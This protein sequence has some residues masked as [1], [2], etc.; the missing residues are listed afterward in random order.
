MFDKCVLCPRYCKVNRDKGEFGYC[1]CGNKMIIARYSLHKWEEPCL[2]GDIGSGTIFFSGCN[3]KC[4]Y[5]QNYEISVLRYGRSVSV[6]EFCYMCLDLQN[7]GAKNINLVTGVMYIPLIVQGIKLAREKGL[8]IPIVYNS[9]GY[10][11][12]EGLKLLE[13]IVDI[14]LPDFKYFDD[15]LGLKYS[16]VRDYNKYAIMAIKEMYRQVGRNK[17][18]KDGI[19]IRGVIVRHLILPGCGDD[20]KKVIKYLYNNYKDNIY[21]SIMNQYTPVRKI[22]IDELDRKIDNDEYDEIINYAYDLGVRCAY[23]QEEGTQSKSFIPNFEE[24]RA[25]E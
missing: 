17:F 14:Y 11:S 25:I 8:R 23:I 13:G 12:I 18:D 22:N 5:C 4:V 6:G 20:S 21:L 9:S 16:N 19:M 10:E 15:K 3:M 2:S 24:F 7:N 1:K